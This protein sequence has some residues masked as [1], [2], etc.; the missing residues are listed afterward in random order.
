MVSPEKVVTES[1]GR[2]TF[3]LVLTSVEL[4][5]SSPLLREGIAD[6][7]GLL[8]EKYGM[9]DH[10]PVRGKD[11]VGGRDGMTGM[12]SAVDDHG[13]RL[14]VSSDRNGM[15]ISYD[16]YN[17]KPQ[18]EEV[19]ETFVVEEEARKLDATRTDRSAEL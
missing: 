5:T 16:D 2:F 10:R 9:L 12:I 11:L 15:F 19:Y 18:M 14:S 3:P 7:Y 6:I 17:V 13:N 1:S 4:G 8:A